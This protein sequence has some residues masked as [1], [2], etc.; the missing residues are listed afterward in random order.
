MNKLI[1]TAIFSLLFLSTNSFA[2]PGKTFFQTVE[3]KWQGTLEYLDYSDDK[4]RVSLK[5]EIEFKT[6]ADGH[7]A[8]VSTIYDDFGKVIK[9]EATQRVDAAAGKYFQGK[10][11]YKIESIADGKIVLLGSGQDGE[12]VEP[13]RETITYTSDTLTILKETRTP[14]RFRHVYTLKRFVENTQPEKIL[15]VSHL[16][17]DFA[18]FK[19][20]L[21]A[22]HPGI[23]RYNTPA[24]LEKDFAEFEAKLDKPLPESAFFVLISQFTNKIR[25]GHT[26]P[27]P[28]NQDDELKGR[29]FDR[30]NYLPFYFRIIDGKM[31]VTENGS[32]KKLAKGSEII[33]INGVSSRK[34]IEKMLTVTKADGNS[35]LEHRLSSIELRRSEAERYAI[36]D[37]YFPLFFPLKDEI[38]T[39]KAIDYATQKPT[40]FQ[41]LAMTKAERAAEMTKRYGTLPTYDDGWKFEIRDNST[42]YLKIENS[43]TWRLKTIKFKEFLASSFAELRAKNV[44]NLIIDLRGNGG[45]DT[46]VGFELVKYLAKR[47]LPEYISVKRLVRNVSAQKDLTKYLDTYSDELKSGLQNGVPANIYRAADNGFFEI[48]PN[49]DTTTYPRI[50][51][52]TNNFRGNAYIISDASNSSATFQFLGYAQKNRLAKII[53]QNS[54]GNKQGINGGNYFF[55]RLPNSKIEVDIPVYYLAPRDLPQTD[56]GV[57]PDVAVKKQ[58]A[59]VGDNYDRELSAVINLIGK[60]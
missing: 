32:S 9:D 14:F 34:I 57:I 46:E 41:V 12:K 15:S 21:T 48:T 3:G 55:L 58:A 11:E 53:G 38:L 37:W 7:S 24:N 36:F 16:R 54:G 47:D 6:A 33:S 29:L 4:S 49:A 27:N 51:P 13:I 5:T 22:V 43:L 42:G 44:A 1:L 23:Y 8:Q 26:F 20:T 10:N 52:D 40:E 25:C 19:R 35:T 56:S 39:V 28:Y 2:Q 50:T 17:E 60:N 59:D 18:V 30:R 31:I 45:G